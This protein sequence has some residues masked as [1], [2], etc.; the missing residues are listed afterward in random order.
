M[1]LGAMWVLKLF[2][3]YKRWTHPVHPPLSTGAWHA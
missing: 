1:R 3:L 2:S